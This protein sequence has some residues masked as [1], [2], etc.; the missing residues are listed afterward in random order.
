MPNLTSISIFLLLGFTLW[1]CSGSTS[2]SNHS[3]TLLTFSNAEKAPLTPGETYRSKAFTLS[4]KPARLVYEYESD[5]PQ[6]GGVFAVFLVP[7]GGS[8]ANGDGMPQIIT[9]AANEKSTQPIEFAPAGRYVLEVAATGNWK[10]EVR[11]EK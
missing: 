8:S 3:I 9:N 2:D 11:Q 1:S 10:I 5:A 4:D 6:I 7:E